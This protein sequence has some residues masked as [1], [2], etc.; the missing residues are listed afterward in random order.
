MGSG[1]H[2]FAALPSQSALP[3]YIVGSSQFDEHNTLQ[4]R[5]RRLITALHKRESQLSASVS[6]LFP[7]KHRI[8]LITHSVT[9]SQPLSVS[10]DIPHSRQGERTI[11]HNLIWLL[12][13]HPI[14]N[15]RLL[16]LLHIQLLQAAIIKQIVKKSRHLRLPPTQS[17]SLTL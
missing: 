5:D 10:I 11:R 2:H 4:H 14:R 16:Q 9:A 12:L 7:L 3:A 15:P 8:P 13:L 17:N 1:S 6:F